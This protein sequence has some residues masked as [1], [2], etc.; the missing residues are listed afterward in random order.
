MDFGF[1]KI[2]TFSPFSTS[3]YLFKIEY[4]ELFQVMIN[5]KFQVIVK[6]YKKPSYLAFLYGLCFY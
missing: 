1:V 6:K 2:A 5:N 4:Q 3:E